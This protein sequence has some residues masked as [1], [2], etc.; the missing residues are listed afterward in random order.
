MSNSLVSVMMSVYNEEKYIEESIE[1]VLQ[2]EYPNIEL[3][4]IDD[5]SEDNTWGIIKGYMDKY[6]NI[7]AYRNEKNLGRP[8]TR[9][10]LLRK[11]NGDYYAVLDADDMFIEGKTKKQVRFLEN[12]PE[13]GVVGSNMFIIDE[14]GKIV[15]DRNY[16]TTYKEIMRKIFYYNLIAHPTT[17]IRSEVFEEHDGY[18]PRYERS[19]DYDL[20]LRILQNWKAKNLKSYLI[21]YRAPKKDKTKAINETVKNNIRIKKKFLFDDYFSL[22]NFLFY[23]LEYFS[24]FLPEKVLYK[25][26][27]KAF[28]NEV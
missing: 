23:S 11:S 28:I 17:M 18:D 27:E 3:V 19:Q 20:W 24:L 5:C 22:S 16:P 21:K 25:V 15:G 13:Y 12:N 4:I 10:K 26:Y 14:E 8:R 6:D 2:Q 1:S 9:N 7:K